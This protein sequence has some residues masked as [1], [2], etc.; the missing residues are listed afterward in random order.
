[1][2]RRQSQTASQRWG[3]T[4]CREARIGG[5]SPSASPS[6]A[7]AIRHGWR[8]A[9][10]PPGRRTGRSADALEA[11]QVAE[12]QL[13]APDGAVRAEARAV[14]DRTDRG[15]AR[16]AR[17]AR[18]RGA[19]GG[20]ARRRAR[21]LA[22][23]RVARSTG[24]PGAGRARRPPAR[25][26]TAARSARRLAERDQGLVVREVAD[27]VPDPARP[28]LAT[29]NVLFSSAPQAE[30][31]RR[32]DRQ[33]RLGHVPARAAQHQ[34]AACGPSTARPRS[35]PCASRS[36][37]RA[38]G[39][40]RRCRRGA[41][42]PRRRVGDRLVGDVAAGHH[43]RRAGVGEQQVVQRRVRKH[44]AELARA[45]RHRRGDRRARVGRGAITIGRT[46]PAEQR[47][48]RRLQ[49]HQLARRLRASAPSAR[50]A[51]PRGACA[52]AAPRPRLVVGPASEM[53]PA[54]ALHGH[55][56]ARAAAPPRPAASGVAVRRGRGAARAR[57]PGRRSAGRGSGGRAD[58]RT[59]RGRRAHLEAGHRGQRPVVGHAAHDREAR[60]AV[61]AVDE[62]VAVPPV[63][64]I[65]QLRQAVVA[66]RAVGG[67][68]RRAC[69]PSA[70]PR[71]RSRARQTGAIASARSPTRSR[72][73]AEPPPG[74]GPGSGRP[75]PGRPRPRAARRARR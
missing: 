72:P 26:R 30:R 8:I 37:G 41:P 61:R 14:V 43:E 47:L 69:S 49:L 10:S 57:N 74:A 21:T 55:D 13:A 62:R 18:R 65:E 33:A 25:R 38:P 11:A 22:L 58:P 67:D 52:R 63:A 28:P 16:R 23:Q 42:A 46:R 2:P 35:R 17:R 39:T 4:E 68:R 59:R 3:S 73:A 1:M 75:P 34:R 64:G 24:S 7:H 60:P 56:R 53:E 6:Q 70:P 5:G 44:H 51:C 29:Q 27:V 20:A 40:G 19:R 50:T 71:S 45:R 32:G 15:P 9:C 48:L 12:Q 54:H 36:G 66:R 31:G